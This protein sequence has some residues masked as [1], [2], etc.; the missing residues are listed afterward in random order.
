M[1]HTPSSSTGLAPNRIHSLPGM[2]PP[3][4]SRATPGTRANTS[5]RA[6]FPPT[7]FSVLLRPLCRPT[8][9]LRPPLRRW[10]RGRR[11]RGVGEYIPE[12]G[13][14]GRVAGQVSRLFVTTFPIS[15]N[16]PELH[17]LHPSTV[18]LSLY[19]LDPRETF[20]RQSRQSPF[21]ASA[22]STEVWTGKGLVSWALE[23]PGAGKNLITGRLM[24]SPAFASVGE[25]GDE[26]PMQALVK[27]HHNEACWGIEISLGLRSGGP[28]MV[29]QPLVA[30]ASVQQRR[31]S[32]AS[33][34]PFQSTSSPAPAST[35]IPARAA[36]KTTLPPRAPISTP[37]AV[38]RV[39][40]PTRIVSTTP[41]TK[42]SAAV[43]P[44]KKNSA[45]KKRK[46]EH[47]HSHSHTPS[48]PP[49]HAHQQRPQKSSN[50]AARKSAPNNS[51]KDETF[52]LPAELFSDPTSLTREQ[53]ERLLESPAFLS[54][55]SALT[56]QPI[57]PRG[58]GAD[59][60][61]SSSSKPGGG[62]EGA[63]DEAPVMK[64][65]NC[66]RTK[67]AVWRMKVMDDGKSVRVCNGA[68]N[69]LYQF[70]RVRN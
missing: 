39:L 1:E 28:P 9:G 45:G 15:N 41:H 57:I 7:L 22:A 63:K 14:P 2:C 51:G 66:G 12:N 52:P 70:F 25:A 36:T 26:D 16:S 46:S 69:L 35:P 40:S 23:E 62:R 32:T 34:S 18:D 27:A 42:A 48:H 55:L 50:A 47:P 64:C 38:E 59:G 17:P 58:R 4:P 56:G 54:K 30:A 21:G 19:I 33:E 10:A 3:T 68:L 13:R 49:T 37:A 61:T 11:G 65:W 60:E 44:P 20:L 43:A 31:L 53:A 6:I 29:N 5:H 24:Q 67:S 8:A